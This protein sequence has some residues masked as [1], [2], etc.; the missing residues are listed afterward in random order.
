M[1]QAPDIGDLDV[2]LGPFKFRVLVVKGLEDLGSFDIEREVIELR[3]G[4]SPTSLLTTFF[5]EVC[6][7]FLHNL[8]VA[9]DRLRVEADLESVCDA[10]GEGLGELL[11]RNPRVVQVL[12][13]EFT[14]KGD[15][16]D[17]T[18]TE[19]SPGHR[20]QPREI[21]VALP[22]HQ[23]ASMVRPPHEPSDVQGRDGH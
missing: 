3:E 1:N 6:H 22:P 5:H 13:E 18:T 19:D 11:L 21:S 8:E 4:Q 17:A 9:G 12:L 16:R 23:D 7:Y 2:R 20:G 14:G 10:V 15:N